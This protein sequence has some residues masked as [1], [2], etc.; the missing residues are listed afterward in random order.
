MGKM[1][2][3]APGSL[4]VFDIAGTPADLNVIE[5]VGAPG[6]L[7]GGTGT[8]LQWLA[9]LI[10]STTVNGYIS[11]AT[12]A[13]VTTATNSTDVLTPA[14]L[15]F[16]SGVADA[17]AVITKNPGVSVA[18]VNSFN[19]SSIT[20]LTTNT[21][22]LTFTKPMNSSDYGVMTSGTRGVSDH[23]TAVEATTPTTIDIWIRLP[24]TVTTQSS[25][26]IYNF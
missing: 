25:T 18:I 2:Q 21:Y 10:S 13:E 19:V 26:A 6:D 1:A 20:D 24:L 15:S 5:S 9:P 11:I 8:G 17:V 7:L 12:D 4:P 14:S 23:Y 3:G 22:R 16:N